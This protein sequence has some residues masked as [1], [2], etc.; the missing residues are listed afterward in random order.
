VG[1]AIPAPLIMPAPSKAAV[2]RTGLVCRVAVCPAGGAVTVV[3]PSSGG[4]REVEHLTARPVCYLPRDCTRTRTGDQENEADEQVGEGGAP[5]LE[6]WRAGHA[7][8]VDPAAAY[9]ALC[10]LGLQ[11]GTCFRPLAAIHQRESSVWTD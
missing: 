11:Y 8:P 5:S 4:G 10:E 6:A 7:L 1:A 3:S 2:G 9:T